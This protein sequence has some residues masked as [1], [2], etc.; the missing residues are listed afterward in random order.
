M[1]LASIREFE[2]TILCEPGSMYAFEKD[3]PQI[4]G[5]ASPTELDQK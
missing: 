5:W 3:E 1:R 2:N 4:V